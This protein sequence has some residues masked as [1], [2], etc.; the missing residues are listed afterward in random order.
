MYTSDEAVS[1][2][3]KEKENYTERKCSR[4]KRIVIRF[5]TTTA[6]VSGHKGER[7]GS[8]R[9]IIIMII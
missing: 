9:V 7:D 2:V 8:K 3:K 4:A 6:H 5:R 1:V